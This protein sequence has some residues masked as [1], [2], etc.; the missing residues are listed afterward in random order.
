MKLGVTIR[1]PSGWATRAALVLALVGWGMTPACT[2][3]HGTLPGETGGSGSGGEGEG[4]G[5][6]DGDI[7]YEGS[8]GSGDEELN[9]DLDD[10]EDDYDP[11]QPD[12]SADSVVDENGECVPS[13]FEA[14]LWCADVDP[15]EC[16]GYP[17]TVTYDCPVCCE[18]PEDEQECPPEGCED[19]EDVED[20]PPDEVC[21]YT[22]TCPDAVCSPDEDCNSCPDDCNECA[23]SCGDGECTDGIESCSNCAEDCECPASCGDEICDLGPSPDGEN[24]ENCPGDCGR[25]VKVLTW[26]INAGLKKG[27]SKVKTTLKSI[28]NKIKQERPDFVGLQSVDKLTNRSGNIDQAL[29]IAKRAKMFKRFGGAFKFDGGQYGVAFLSKHKIPSVQKVELPT[30]DE[31]AKRRVLLNASIELDDFYILFHMGVTQL[32][33]SPKSR[34]KQAEIIAGDLGFEPDSLLVGDMFDTPASSPLVELQ[35]TG[36]LLD[37]WPEYGSGGKGLTTAKK[38]VD[39]V[40]ASFNWW[41]TSD[42]GRCAL[43]VRSYVKPAKGLASHRPVVTLLQ[44]GL[45][46][47]DCAAE[48]ESDPYDDS[49]PGGDDSIGLGDGACSSNADCAADPLWP[50]CIDGYC[51]ECQSNTDCKDPE[52]PTCTENYCY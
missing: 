15:T 4:A 11:N 50:F 31:W 9:G 25:C 20:C 17:L 22:E 48:G 34:L 40:M 52:Y 42:P 16:D 29:Y 14:G 1:W 10:E 36:T 39:Y 33:R 6:L 26:D 24:C 27:K 43:V 37:L 7:D 35:S 2:T 13:C 21:T 51:A 23:P 8:T 47:V 41:D 19:D 5:D 30:A 32:A 49:E 28:A 38:R 46:G 44:R 12:C 3:P 45:G 18:I